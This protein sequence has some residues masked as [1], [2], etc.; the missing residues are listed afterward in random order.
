M[1][2]NPQLNDITVGE[3]GKVYVSGTG[4]NTIY[5]LNENSLEA[6]FTGN[7]GERFNGLFSEKERMLLVTSGSSQFKEVN[8]TTKAVKT[9]L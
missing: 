7:E 5:Q 4:S 8:L 2:G 1:E 9:A 3:D 6:L